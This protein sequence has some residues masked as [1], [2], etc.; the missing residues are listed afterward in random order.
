MSRDV[1]DSDNEFFKNFLFEEMS[2][3]DSSYNDVTVSQLLTLDTQQLVN[4]SFDNK[5]NT[6]PG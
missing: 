4:D 2:N 5:E 6:A 1:L 3:F